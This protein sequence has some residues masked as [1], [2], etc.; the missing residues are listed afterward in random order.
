M[1][2]TFKDNDYL[3]QGLM[4]GILRVLKSGYLS[5]LN[6]LDVYSLLDK[7]STFHTD[8]G[9]T[10]E[11][12]VESLK[13][14]GLESQLKDVE[15]WYDGYSIG[16]DSNIR[17]FNPWSVLHFLRNKV[18]LPYWVQTGHT[19]FIDKLLVNS[20]NDIN[21]KM[22]DLLTG[23]EVEVVVN[24]DIDY[25][26][27]GTD[28]SQIWSLLFFS[29]YITGVIEDHSSLFPKI[30][31]RIP[32]KEVREAFEKI[33]V[34]HFDHRGTMYKSLGDSLIKGK[35]DDW[36]K[37]LQ[38]TV[39]QS[40]GVNAVAHPESAYHLFI[41][42]SIAATQRENYDITSNHLSGFGRYDLCLKSKSPNMNSF[43]LEFKTIEKKECLSKI[44]R[45]RKDRRKYSKKIKGIG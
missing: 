25:K 4:T 39:L 16:S 42:G 29:G 26:K 28:P 44:E 38:E 18:I 45:N 3:W 41:F 24:Q 17:L 5:G 8:Y 10:H 43:I 31:A 27:L 2:S 14:E 40:F 13:Y 1:T 15:S 34:Y 36:A 35:I 9:V 11:E 32:N 6:N 21:Q 19:E 20:N 23:K 30:S 37:E 33:F 7:N 12:V 22:I